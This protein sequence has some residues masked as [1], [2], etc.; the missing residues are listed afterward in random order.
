MVYIIIT[1][2]IIIIIISFIVI[3]F[4]VISLKRLKPSCFPHK[5]GSLSCKI[6]DYSDYLEP[7]RSLG[8]WLCRDETRSR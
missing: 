2:I 8:R 3:N 7:L 5:I 4:I 1:V 6:T